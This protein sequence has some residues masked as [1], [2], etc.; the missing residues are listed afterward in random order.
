MPG[1]TVHVDLDTV[2]YGYEIGELEIIVQKDIEI[3]KAEQKLK[4]TAAELGDLL[5]FTVHVDSTNPLEAEKRDF[6][7]EDT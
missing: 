5:L 1:G 7:S 6:D 4:D 2:S 3:P